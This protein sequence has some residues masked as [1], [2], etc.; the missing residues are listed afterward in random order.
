MFKRLI[1]VVLSLSIVASLFA[2][3]S[4]SA[5][6]AP[7]SSTEKTD[8]KG[9]TVYL[10]TGS[11]MTA[12][13]TDKSWDI[14]PEKS[15]IR[16]K[17]PV[18]VYY[19]INESFKTDATSYTNS[20]P[21]VTIGQRTKVDDRDVSSNIGLLTKTS[22]FT[23]DSY[24]FIKSGLKAGLFVKYDNGTASSSKPTDLINKEEL[25]YAQINYELDAEATI[26]S[27]TIGSDRSKG[28]WQPGH[29]KV[30]VADTEDDLW[31][32]ENCVSEMDAYG[33]GVSYIVAKT[34]LSTPKTGKWVGL[35]LICAYNAVPTTTRDQ[36]YIRM[37]HFNVQG[38]YTSSVDKDGY[39]ATA[40]G[41][42][43]TAEATAV[44]T[45][46]GLSD[47]TGAFPSASVALTAT[48]SYKGTNS[49]IYTF[50]GWYLGEEKVADTATATYTLTGAETTKE[51]IA[52]Y[53][54]SEYIP[55]DTSKYSV[56]GTHW[57]GQLD[58][59]PAAESLLVGKMPISGLLFNTIEGDAE[60]S[61]EIQDYT[62]KLS[63][64]VVNVTATTYGDAFFYNDSKL[65]QNMFVETDE[66][67][68]FK[69]NPITDDETKQWVQLNYELEGSV[70]IEHIL[71]GR[72]TGPSK[73]APSHYKLI[74]SDTE[75]GLTTLGDAKAVI[76]VVAN[77]NSSNKATNWR[78]DFTEEITA[79]YVGIRIIGM[80]NNVNM[81]S[82]ENWNG[83]TSES[84]YPRFQHL[85]VHGTYVDSVESFE[86]K[87][88]TVEV[89]QDL[90]QSLVSKSEGSYGNADKDGKYVT[91]NVTIT[92]QKIYVDNENMANYI[93]EGWYDGET[94][95]TSDA[96]YVY[97]V[98]LGSK[99]FTAKY[100][101]TELD[102]NSM[103]VN[104]VLVEKYK[105]KLN[106][107]E[108]LMQEGYTYGYT[109]HLTWESE[110]TI[111]YRVNS[112]GEVTKPLD[113]KGTLGLIDG[114]IGTHVDINNPKFYN[115]D[116]QLIEGT[117]VDV[118]INLLHVTELDAL[119]V[120]L[121]NAEKLRANK[122]SVYIIENGV[123]FTL[124]PDEKN[125]QDASKNRVF[126]F[127]NYG[128]EQCQ[129]FE[130]PEG[131]KAKYIG[132]RIYNPIAAGFEQD[133]DAS[134]SNARLSELGV[135]GK[136]DVEYFDYTYV[137]SMGDL[138]SDS[139]EAYIGQK[140]DFT[141]PLTKNGYSFKHFTVNGNEADAD[142]DKDNNLATLKAEFAESKQIVAVYENDPVALSSSNFDVSA[143]GKYVKVNKGDLVHKVTSGFDQYK[144]NIA[145]KDEETDVQ[146]HQFVKSG[147]TLNLSANGA[148]AQS[149]ELVIKGDYNGDSETNVLDMVAAVDAIVN[150]VEINEGGV[151]AVDNGDN[152]LTVTDIMIT[153]DIVLNEKDYTT[154]YSSKTFDMT[155]LKY[156]AMGRTEVTAGN[157]LYVK[158]SASGILFNAD[159]YGDVKVT[160]EGS[161]FRHLTV[162]VDG[163]EHVLRTD[164]KG[165]HT[166]V[167]AEDLEPGVH[168]I[169]IYN[170]KAQDCST[171]YSSV[172][173]NG[174]ILDAPKDKDLLIEFV[175]DSITCGVGNNS[176]NLDAYNEDATKAY[177]RLTAKALDA[178]W[179]NISLGG[180]TVVSKDVVPQSS[181][182]MPENY[183]VSYRGGNKWDFENERQADIVVINLGTNEYLKFEGA[184]TTVIQAEFEDALYKFTKK[185][186]EL[187]SKKDVKVVYAFG[188]MFGER[189]G[190][191]V[192]D[193]YQNVV[194]KL[195]AEGI[196]VPYCQL[197]ENMDGAAAH[198]DA[199]GHVAAAEVLS[200]FIR[201]NVLN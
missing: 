171:I 133:V 61:N 85:G 35:R 155:T 118:V 168:T 18:S 138:V 84:V 199:P 165:D 95:V 74:L 81:A 70:N 21:G 50:A 181:M 106:T 137:S 186:M 160:M 184:D 177:G 22:G 180:S 185:V 55:Y 4:F 189:E 53:T 46:A 99:T 87:E 78:F 43:D 101:M 3:L 30:Y 26:E 142:V 126:E 68:N 149:A 166:Y 11:T 117:Y 136:Y 13:A 119:F 72:Y 161:Q 194:A 178:D 173:V 195:A 121:T 6:A 175:G 93:F 66:E 135:F 174:E 128:N 116:H 109:D 59:Y 52:K 10:R 158:H 15:L 73:W 57:A 19:Y 63:G 159:C 114:D 141:A 14:D 76:E 140:I 112:S 48:N 44:V 16:T 147:M 164:Y 198:P 151:F 182:V 71:F 191:W 139:G 67:G 8:E 41:A 123:P 80:Y 127:T 17:A 34:E 1:S 82:S 132:I 110:G 58:T 38:A 77:T 27:V 28:P 134:V 102:E 36:T 47:K 24:I 148:V 37:D 170:Q 103:A 125:G 172:T 96:K 124:L 69:E 187:N 86:G 7:T 145:V 167:V 157:R 56:T 79:K 143:D 201:E 23:N 144:N 192:I 179:S 89:G 153:R 169:E 107:K 104:P 54:E 176:K 83:Q 129:V 42:D 154:D 196:E 90:P 122:Y 45:E 152:E 108:N 188:M 25:Q 98:A 100:T 29:W 131:T 130:F 146:D 163:V 64:N 92:A 115:S 65:K 9:N 5:F 60:V 33:N 97:N 88:V 183:L 156:K 2:G 105:N 40:Q 150:D 39:T 94:K 193:A 31:K 190:I 62:S 111:S 49:K 113:N 197:P 20:D 120:G 91:C 75:E 51:F 12:C 32:E 162:V 200:Q